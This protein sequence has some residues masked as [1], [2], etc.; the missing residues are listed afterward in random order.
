MRQPI[1]IL[2]VP[3]EL[4]DKSVALRQDLQTCD[5]KFLAVR[6]ELTIEQVDTELENWVS[7]LISLR[8]DGRTYL[9]RWEKINEDMQRFRSALSQTAQRLHDAVNPLIEDGTF[10]SARAIVECLEELYELRSNV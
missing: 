3:D 6:S 5:K 1:D 7:T 4:K 2:A 10:P 9:K 8:E